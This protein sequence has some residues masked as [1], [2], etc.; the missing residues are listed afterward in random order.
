M[1]N[2]II[3]SKGYYLCCQKLCS[4]FLRSSQPLFGW[5]HSMGKPQNGIDYGATICP[6]LKASQLLAAVWVEKPCSSFLVHR[7]SKSISTRVVNKGEWASQIGW[8]RASV[9]ECIFEKTRLFLKWTLC[10][11][12]LQWCSHGSRSKGLYSQICWSDCKPCSISFGGCLE[13]PLAWI[14]IYVYLANQI[15]ATCHA[16]NHLNV[17]YLRNPC[18]LHLSSKMSIGHVGMQNYLRQL[19]CHCSL[20]IYLALV[21]CGMMF[22]DLKTPH[23]LLAF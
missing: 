23:I 3:N 7:W 18:H 20:M 11:W 22:L 4:T 12:Y 6:S 14:E 19:S 8:S 16:W 5:E 1:I 2:L 17:L 13:H 9:L 21:T 15:V 10:K